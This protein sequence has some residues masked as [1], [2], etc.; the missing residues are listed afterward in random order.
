MTTSNAPITVTVG[1]E[2]NNKTRP[3]TLLMRTSNK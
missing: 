1:L 2:H 3:T